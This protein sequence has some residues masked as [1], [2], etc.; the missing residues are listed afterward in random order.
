MESSA[1]SAP[2]SVVRN[3]PLTA[4][5]ST[6]PELATSTLPESVNLRE[7]TT[8]PLSSV[9]PLTAMRLETRAFESTEKKPPL[10]V[11][12]SATAEPSRP[13]V[14]ESVTVNS[15]M[16]PPSMVTP[17][18]ET[19]KSVTSAPLET[20]RNPPCIRTSSARA[21]DSICAIPE[22]V[23]VRPEISPPLMRAPPSATVR[24]VTAAPA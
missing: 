1:I 22:L 9:A 17:P 8:P 20:V 11:I 7:E 14:P 21:P 2:S 6:R 4:I 10:T 3:P 13:A 24:S 23:K 12:S 16:E 18:S 15:P 5:F 19:L